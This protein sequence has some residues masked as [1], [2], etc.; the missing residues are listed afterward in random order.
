MQKL[1]I[2]RERGEGDV[3]G[4]GAP[5]GAPLQL[6]YFCHPEPANRS[7]TSAVFALVGVEFSQRGICGS[8]APLH[9]RKTNA[10]P[11]LAELYPNKRKNGACCGPVRRLGMTKVREL[12]WRA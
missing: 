4:R 1:I 2:L 10:D 8:P 6:P 9:R 12:Q 3:R 11:S 7:A 5:L